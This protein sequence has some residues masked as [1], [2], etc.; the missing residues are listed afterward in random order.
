MQWAFMEQ[1]MC[2]R[3]CARPWGAGVQAWSLYTHCFASLVS[4]SRI[5]REG[6]PPTLSVVLH[7]C[8]SLE[9]DSALGF[10]LRAHSLHLCTILLYSL[11]DPVRK[12]GQGIIP[13]WYQLTGNWSA[14][15]QEIL[16]L[17]QGSVLYSAVID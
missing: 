8:T 14:G 1:A 16:R 6:T 10:A 5:L 17:H 15:F 2:A 12:A 13:T 9:A 11:N 4:L 7:A 3:L